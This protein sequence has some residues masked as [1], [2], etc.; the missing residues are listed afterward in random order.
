M[1]TVDRVIG[2]V[3]Y[4]VDK[5]KPLSIAEISRD[6]QLNK[7]GVYRILRFLKEAR[8]VSQQ[9]D[10]G[11]YYLGP[12]IVKLSS[13]I[14]SK[15]DIRSA[16]QPY[17]EEVCKITKE[18]ALLNLRIGYE[19]IIIDQVVPSNDMLYLVPFGK[20]MPLWLGSTGKAILALLPEEEIGI[21]LDYIK[22]S[23]QPG[24]ASGEQTNIGKIRQQL[25]KVKEDG[26]AVSTGE[27]VSGAI[28]IAAPIFRR[29]HKVVGSLAM[30][31]PARKLSRSEVK[32]YGLLLKRL[33]EE[34]S[35]RL[36]DF[37]DYDY[38][39]DD[40][41]SLHA[42]RNGEG[43]LQSSESV[44]AVNM[45]VFQPANIKPSS[46]SSNSKRRGKG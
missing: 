5:E 17:L 27:V 13:A 22:K 42:G 4:L 8:W 12:G 26:F 34:I 7:S 14:L 35:L 41:R 21:A 32:K 45:P 30:A 44:E 11:L 31:T 1:N 19:R 10:T 15:Y 6:L 18:T 36:G 43:D 39:L 16:S 9:P 24:Y 23:G 29:D 38:I 37:R 25:E 20:R 3:S 2:I 40:F 46:D 28:G 33:S